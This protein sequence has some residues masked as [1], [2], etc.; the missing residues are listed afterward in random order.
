MKLVTTDAALDL[1][2]PA[3]T[4]DARRSGCRAAATTACSTARS[5]SRAAATRSWWSSASGC[6]CAACSSSACARSA[7]T[8]CSTA[9]PSRCPATAPADFDGEP[10][11]PYNVQPDAL[12]LNYKSLMLTFAPD[13]ARGVARVAPSRRWPA[14]AVDA[15][16]PLCRPA[17]CDDWRGALKADF[18]D[19]SR[20]RFGGSYPVACGERVWP[21]AYADPA[22]YNARADRGAVARDRRPARR[23]RARRR[24]AGGRS[25]ASSSSR[26]RWPRWCATSTSTATT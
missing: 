22:S 12:L 13:P 19:P 15:S 2:G 9:A 25:R 7:A 6:C 5:S 10:L 23:P 20:L 21:I 17:A 24:R 26:R 8:S 18:A 1:L 16:V 14:C 3:W 11:R 4:L